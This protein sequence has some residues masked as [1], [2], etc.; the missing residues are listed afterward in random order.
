MRNR[1]RRKNERCAVE[2][3]KAEEEEDTKPAATVKSAGSEDTVAKEDQKPA[4]VVSPQRSVNMARGSGKSA[5]TDRTSPQASSAAAITPDSKPAKKKRR[6]G[7]KEQLSVNKS[8]FQQSIGNLN[9]PEKARNSG[10]EGIRKYIH[11]NELP[12]KFPDVLKLMDFFF[13]GGS[14]FQVL[15]LDATR[16][17]R[18]GIHTRQKLR[19]L[20]DRNHP[21]VAWHEPR[22]EWAPRR[23]QD[24]LLFIPV[25]Q[26]LYEDEHED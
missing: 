12:A 20:S 8:T 6:T 2:Q 18:I 16:A 3:T 1:R 4:V 10:L 24:L 19:K 5:T 23:K 26:S 25:L 13:E 9:L 11:D 14:Y 15:W 22:K 21:G 7:K 17:H